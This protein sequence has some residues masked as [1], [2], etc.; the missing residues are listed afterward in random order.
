MDADGGAI[1]GDGAGSVFALVSGVVAD[2]RSG[3]NA[4]SR[5]AAIDDSLQRIV[6]G[7]AEVGTRQAHL[8][9]AD[10][11]LQQVRTALDALRSSIE[12]ADVGRVILD[13]KL[14]ETNY[15]A[16]LAVTAKVLQ[17]TLMDFVR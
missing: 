14:Q 4:G 16:A 8:Q 5:L 7:R 6:N 10:Y 17:P 15:Q 3:A 2:I 9:H 11:S 1:F 13:L 12:D